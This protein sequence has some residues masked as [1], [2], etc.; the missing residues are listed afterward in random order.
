M[1]QPSATRTRLI[2]V[3]FLLFGSGF[4]A[5]IYQV[6]WMRELRLVF[7]ASTAA[8]A[9]VTAV[10]M[11]GLGIGSAILGKYADRHAR[12]LMMYAGLEMIIALLAVASPL[13]VTAARFVYAA[14]GGSL[15]MG[16]LMGTI[17]RLLLSAVV[18]GG[19]TFAM[20]GTLPAAARALAIEGDR[21]RKRVAWLYGMNTAG[22]VTGAFLA[23]FFMLE[24][25]GLRD[26]LYIGA[27][28]NGLVAIL[29]RNMARRDRKAPVTAN[30]D[31][32]SE[33]PPTVPAT[34]KNGILDVGREAPFVY[35]ATFVV[36]FVFFLMELVWYRMLG[37]ILGGTTYSYGLILAV[38]LL[39]IGLGSGLYATVGGSARGGMRTFSITCGLEAIAL[40]VPYV[41]GDWIAVFA[42]LVQPLRVLGLDGQLIIWGMVTA[43]VV[44]PAAIVAGY[45]FPL[46]IGLL[47]KGHQDIGRHTGNAYAFNTAGAIIGSLAGGFGLIGALSAPKCWLLSVVLL[48]SLSVAAAVLGGVRRRMPSLAA[49]GIVAVVVMVAVFSVPGP[50]AAWR[51]SPIGAGR[52]SMAD[53][54]F[55]GIRRWMAEA[56]RHIVWEL[57]GKESSV[58]LQR[59]NG[60][61]FIVN[62]KIDGNALG[63]APTQIMSG[64]IGAALHPEPKKSMVIG[65]G[66]GSSAG[67]L[68]EV[69]TMERVDV[70]EIEPAIL[71]VAKACTGVNRNV[72]ENP[73]INLMIADAREV[74]TT[75]RNTYDLIFSEPSNPYR[76]GI[77]SLYTREF[78]WEAADG[79]ARGSLS[80][81]RG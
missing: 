9:A 27:L 58:A 77:A 22:A 46:L 72:L 34:Q 29:A 66:T 50:T 13:L 28:I 65:L 54:D 80:D 56:R 4:S 67:W 69:K 57:D 68:A 44:L 55:N 39:G 14:A 41:I 76:A 20:G 75:T 79:R 24:M 6:V 3:S 15:A 63:D 47:G 59:E 49:G 48:L 60:L 2:K 31:T 1:I 64:L 33:N 26:T 40:A 53:G 30:A 37:P 61:A 81:C 8:T 25:F 42:V 52:V 16:P 18:L 17:A 70:V 19:V 12:P 23:T 35:T 11:G 73:K 43:V 10:F 71:D 21:D 78:Y 45:Q 74:L 32:G 51:H 7:G 38:A 5:L 36:G 62:G